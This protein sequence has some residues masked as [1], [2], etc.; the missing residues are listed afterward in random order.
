MQLLHLRAR[1]TEG[2]A[3]G[4]VLGG[5]DGSDVRGV[6]FADSALVL[7]E[8]LISPAVFAHAERGS[9]LPFI[10][11]A[12][13]DLITESS[14]VDLL[15]REALSFAESELL[16]RS[17]V[18]DRGSLADYVCHCSSTEFPTVAQKCAKQS[19]LSAQKDD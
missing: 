11:E 19:Q 4:L 7:L 12:I 6:N 18:V 3:E 9:D 13:L 1:D 17:R 8:L 16:L 2:V 5:I 14:R 10:A 15:G